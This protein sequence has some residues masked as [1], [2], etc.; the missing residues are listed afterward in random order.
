MLRAATKTDITFVPYG[1]SAPAVQAN[2]FEETV[3]AVV[4][5]IRDAEA[6]AR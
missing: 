4:N 3:E 2:E 6:R 1:G 5:A